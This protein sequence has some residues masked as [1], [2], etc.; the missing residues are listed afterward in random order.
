MCRVLD[1]KYNFKKLFKNIKKKL[2]YVAEEFLY[3][4]FFNFENMQ[5][6]QL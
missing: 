3:F 4:F 2:F 6:F 1:S 5:N